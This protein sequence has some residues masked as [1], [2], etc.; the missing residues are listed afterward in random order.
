LMLRRHTLF[1]E[2]GGAALAEIEAINNRLDEIGDSIKSDFP[3][4]QAEVEDFRT[5]LAEQILAIHNAEE[6]A[7]QA[8]KDATA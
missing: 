1:L 7:V 6:T 3:L 5:R 2:Q 8:L 4:M